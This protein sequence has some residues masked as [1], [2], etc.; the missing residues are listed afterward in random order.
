MDEKLR[1]YS[2]KAIAIATFLGGP[3]A[4]GVLIR[5]NAL[6]LGREKEGLAALIIGIVS[7]V[8]LFWGLF[9]IPEAI[10]DKI[11]NFLIPAVYMGIIYLIVEK[12]HGQI[13]KKHQEENNE[14]YSNWNAAGIGF[15]CAI[16]L[17]AGFFAYIFLAPESFYEL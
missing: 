1:L 6:N 11:P 8:L 4:A 15:V 9:Q 7:T 16:V 12:M 2:Q 13:L 10:I 17:C 14:F 5:K 3:L